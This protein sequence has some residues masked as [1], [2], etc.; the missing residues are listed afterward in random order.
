MVKI[1]GCKKLRVYNIDI[2]PN[3]NWRNLKLHAMKNSEKFFHEL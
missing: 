1:F 2:K 3:Q